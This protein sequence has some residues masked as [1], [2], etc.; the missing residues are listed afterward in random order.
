LPTDDGMPLDGNTSEG[1]QGEEQGLPEFWIQDSPIRPLGS[2]RRLALRGPRDH[3]IKDFTVCSANECA[4][5]LLSDTVG[6]GRATRW[7]RPFVRL[8]VPL[9][10]SHPRFFIIPTRVCLTSLF[11][12]R[13]R[14]WVTTLVLGAP[15]RVGIAVVGLHPIVVTNS[16]ALAI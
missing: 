12:S 7:S 8:S 10:H 11:L 5:Q 1:V 6:S 13:L 16:F 14:P 3:L 4:L 9:R 15:T 2:R